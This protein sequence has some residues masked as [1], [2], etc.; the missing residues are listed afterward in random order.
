MKEGCVLWCLCRVLGCSDFGAINPQANPSEGPACRIR[1]IPFDD[2]FRLGGHDKHAPP[3][4]VSD[5]PA[6]QGRCATLDRSSCWIV[7]PAPAGMTS[8]PL[9]HGHDKRFPPTPGGTC[10]SGPVRYPG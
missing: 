6:C 8:M 5:G 10:L 2:L 1:G 4:F 7:H 9:Q 3:I